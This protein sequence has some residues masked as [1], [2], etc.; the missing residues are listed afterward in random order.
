MKAAS[1]TTEYCTG[2]TGQDSPT[3]AGREDHAFIGE[4]WEDGL[5]DVLWTPW[6]GFGL[7]GVRI[8]WSDV[9]PTPCLAK[10]C[11]PHLLE[12]LIF[13]WS[14]NKRMCA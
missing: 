12:K 3:V 13:P 2:Q 6:A 7:G 14:V 9:A 8:R 4:Y 5:G 11:A 10:T 1:G